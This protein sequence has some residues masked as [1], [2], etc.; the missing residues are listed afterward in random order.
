MVA[1][2]LKVQSDRAKTVMGVVTRFSGSGPMLSS[3]TAAQAFDHK[4]CTKGK[5]GW[6]VSGGG[7]VWE[8]E[9]E[10][11]K[12]REREKGGRKE[13]RKEGRK[14]GRTEG[15]KEGREEGRKGG[16]KDGRTEERKAGMSY[17]S[18]GVM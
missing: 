9:R 1:Q 11:K 7:E 13:G 10:R 6:L 4:H 17:A 3:P 8:S 5:R 2:R 12:E 14:D 18:F 16:R 15:R